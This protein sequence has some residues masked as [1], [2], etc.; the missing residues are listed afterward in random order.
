MKSVIVNIGQ[1]KEYIDIAFDNDDNIFKY[2]DRSINVNNELKEVCISIFNKIQNEYSDGC[3]YGVELDGVKIGY[4]VTFNQLLVS[5]S[6]NYEYREKEMLKMFF[7]LI[8]ISFDGSF[9]CL[10]YSHNKRAIYWL[11]KCGAKVVF[12]NVSLLQFNN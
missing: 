5:F 4:F 11:E 3:F 12:E 6:I 2:F 7:E 8:K 9:Q 1:L 10:L